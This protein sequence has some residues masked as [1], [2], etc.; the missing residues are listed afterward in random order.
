VSVGA[1]PTPT[2]PGRR[3]P[4]R[5]AASLLVLACAISLVGLPV[6]IVD[7]EGTLGA[8]DVAVAQT[9]TDAEGVTA[10]A[11]WS[12]PAILSG[13]PGAGAPHVVFPSDSPTHGTGPGAIVWSTSSPCPAGAGVLVSAIS[14]EDD[15]PGQPALPRTAAGQTIALRGSV[16]ATPGP[17]GRIVI[18]GASAGEHTAPA[19]ELLLTEGQAGGSFASPTALGGPA[20]TFAFTTAYLGDV[21]FAS[22][23]DAPSGSVVQPSGGSEEHLQAGRI[24]SVRPGTSPGGVGNDGTGDTAAGDPAGTGDESGVQL[25]VQRHHADGFAA[26]AQVGAAGAGSSSVQALTVALDYRS[27]ALVVWSQ[28]GSLY[29][30]ELPA[31]G[32]PQPVQRLGWVGIGSPAGARIAAVLSDDDRAIVAWTDRHDGQTSVYVSRSQPGVRFTGPQLLEDFPD[33]PD[34]PAYVVSP[35]LVRLSSE[36]VMLAWT[37]AVAGHW[38]IRVAAIDLHGVRPPSTVSPAGQDALLAALAPGPDDEALALWTEPL[39]TAA[40]LDLDSQAIF[41]ARGFDAYPGHTAFAAGE[42]VAPPGPN[43]EATVALDP[44]SGRAVA[45]WRTGA[46]ELAYSIRA[47]GAP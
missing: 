42:E 31:S 39:Q 12:Q 47:P 21:A 45:A 26:P 22:L 7:A 34:L 32:A 29:A 19:G 8:A 2:F 3:A 30:R 18:A 4:G 40:G 37:G 35:R 23:I 41:A 1:T 25:R 38:A 10:A 36:S 17:Y 20:S 11:K 44:D 28:H 33:P 24:G 43:S 15:V 9:G 6:A 13:C 16:A 46:G 14:P 5:T 27:D